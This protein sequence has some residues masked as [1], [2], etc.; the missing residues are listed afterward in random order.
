MIV[1]AQPH[2]DRVSQPPSLVLLAE[3]KFHLRILPGKLDNLVTKMTSNQGDFINSDFQKRLNDMSQNGFARNRE[4]TFLYVV[5]KR[6]Q[7]GTAPCDRNDS[8]QY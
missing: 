1:H 7:S 6:E 4:Q 2:S 8:F 5:G 3:L